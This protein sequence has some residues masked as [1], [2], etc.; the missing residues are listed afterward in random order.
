MWGHWE[1]AL[2]LL[3]EM[4]SK[5]IKKDLLT[6]N[7][8][9]VA[10]NHAHKWHLALL[11]MNEMSSKSFT[12]D[13]FSFRSCI[14]ALSSSSNWAQISGLMA[15]MQIHSLQTD[16]TDWG[17]LLSALRKSD[18]G[19][20]ALE[21][22]EAYR[23]WCEKQHADVTGDQGLLERSGK[24]SFQDSSANVA[25]LATAPGVIVVSKLAGISSQ[26]L[27][28]LMAGHLSSV[29]YRRGVCLVSRLDQ[30]TSGVL[31]IV[32][33]SEKSGAGNWYQSQFAARWTAKEYLCL[34]AGPEAW[35]KGTELEISSPLLVLNS[36][37]RSSSS[38][39]SFGKESSTRFCIL[40]VFPGATTKYYLLHAAPQTGRTHQI[41]CH[42]A[43]IG[44]PLLGDGSY[45]LRPSWCPRLFLHCHRLSL[46]DM[47]GGVLQAEAP[48]SDDL[49]SILTRL[50]EGW[51]LGDESLRADS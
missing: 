47:A 44:A 48:L 28:E 12:K 23:V 43:S 30:Q 15:E 26:D 31:P 20:K 17:A 50:R 45:G 39:Q 38:V 33:G 2:A 1:Q 10:L 40:E 18:R 24:V 3:E 27:L 49:T 35:A 16:G 51:R 25:V 6:Y 29:G 11:M 22:R 32:L 46:Q 5:D 36:G 34:S 41:R 21:L 37:S 14:S 19:S 42:I 13:A 4:T 8:C 9:I 7:S